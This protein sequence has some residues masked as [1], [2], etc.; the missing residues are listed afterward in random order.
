MKDSQASRCAWSELKSCSRPSS[1][2]FLVY[3][4]QRRTA[5]LAGSIPRLL[6]RCFEAEEQRTRPVSAG[7][8]ECHFRQRAIPFAP[9]QCAALDDGDFVGLAAPLAHENRSGSY[10]RFRSALHG[11]S[12][13]RSVC[14]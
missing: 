13:A 9:V 4:A 14:D 5:D 11:A 3:T 12:S 7:Y 1:E 10:L 2:D 8:M 6:R